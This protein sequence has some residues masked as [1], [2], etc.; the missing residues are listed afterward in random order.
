MRGLKPQGFGSLLDEEGWRIVKTKSTKKKERTTIADEVKERSAKR[1]LDL[2][3]NKCFGCNLRGHYIAQCP[4]V[5]C[6]QCQGVGHR[7]PK[8]SWNFKNI[9]LEGGGAT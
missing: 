7:A 5:I 4:K 3:S 1:K 8:C 9:K 6:F 2:T